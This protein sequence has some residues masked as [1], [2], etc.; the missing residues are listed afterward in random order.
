MYMAQVAVQK[1]TP[2]TR[3]PSVL[4]ALIKDDLATAAR[5]QREGDDATKAATAPYFAAAG[6]KMLEAKAQMPHGQFTDWIRK[7]FRCGIRNA[8]LYMSIARA[9]MDLEKRNAV[10]LME[11]LSMR[12]MLR[13][14]TPNVNFGKPAKWRAEVEDNIRQAREQAKRLEHESLTRQQEREAEKKL[15]LQLISIGFKALASKLHP[16]KG[17][18]KDAM[19]RLGRVRDRL[20][21][22]A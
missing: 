12:E 8:Q 9:A 10:S 5:V 1:D 7:N 17:G 14:H 15:A 22:H 18:T 4:V 13:E 6:E 3:S 21:Q 16:D 2:V 20:K 11:D 19:A